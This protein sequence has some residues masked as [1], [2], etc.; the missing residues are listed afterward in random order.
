MAR[1]LL[2][3]RGYYVVRSAGSRGAIDLVAV[4]PA[5][6][7]LVQ[8]TTKGTERSKD[9]DAFSAIQ[10]PLNVTRQLWVWEPYRDWIITTVERAA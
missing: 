5:G 9:L 8:V 1:D 3:S 10:A 7:L 6:I 4:G 2:I